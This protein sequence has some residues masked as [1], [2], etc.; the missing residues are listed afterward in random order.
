MTLRRRQQIWYILADLISSE[1]VWLCFL[2][3]RWMVYEGRVGLLEN[4]L[5][6]AFEFLPPL[7]I[8]S[9]GVLACL[10]PVR[11]LSS[12][13]PKAAL[14]RVSTHFLLVC[15]HLAPILLFHHHR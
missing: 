9:A 4:V 11:I 10:L 2:G 13:L 15:C 3:F 5:V 6:P 12:P 14:A 7:I 1:L 8:L